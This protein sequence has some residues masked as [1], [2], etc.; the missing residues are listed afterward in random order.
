VDIAGCEPPKA[1]GSAKLVFPL[2]FMAASAVTSR[3]IQVPVCR[4]LSPEKI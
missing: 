2:R 3:V 4:F 1:Q